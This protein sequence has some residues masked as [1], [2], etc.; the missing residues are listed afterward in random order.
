MRRN[1]RFRKYRL[2]LRALRAECPVDRPVR[3]RLEHTLAEKFGSCNE[4][5]NGKGFTI[6]V[7]T[8]GS[9][10]SELRDTIVHEWAHA[11]AWGSETEHGPEWGVAYA[12]AYRA[13]VED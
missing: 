9:S 4:T 7:F 6:T 11:M 12:R 1:D 13:T 3:V 10:A 2:A 8:K 5:R